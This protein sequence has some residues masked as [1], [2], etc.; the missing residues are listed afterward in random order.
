M[1]VDDAFGLTPQE[2]DAC[3]ARIAK[4]R[5]DG[6]F[7]PPS[8]QG[9]VAFPGSLGGMN[10]SSGAFDPAHQMFVTNVNILPMD[11]R[12]VPR[13]RYEAVGA[14]RRG[15]RRASRRG[16]APA[17]NAARHEPRGAAFAGRAALQCAAMGC[18]G[19]RRS[20]E[21]VDPVERAARIHGGH[22]PIITGGGLVFI[23]AAM[24]NYL[25]A[26]DIDTGAE[27][28]KGRLPAGGQAMPMTYQLR[29]DGKQFVVIAAG[30]HGKLGTKLGDSLV[31]YVLP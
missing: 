10:W 3:R 26:F 31:A 14:R 6:I 1:S 19:R 24:D 18:A 23:A 17:R 15:A 8:V 9:T 20:G 5:T 30:G 4:L 7:T 29:A 25:R 13:D 21:W 16:L 2:R 12:L 11:V 27:L 22:A 28:W